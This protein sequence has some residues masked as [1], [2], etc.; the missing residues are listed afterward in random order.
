[1][2]RLILTL[3][4]ASFLVSCSN[5]IESFRGEWEAIDRSR[6]IIY[7]GDEGAQLLMQHSSSGRPIPYKF[8][9]IREG[10][11]GKAVATHTRA[12]ALMIIRNQGAP[13]ALWIEGK[14]FERVE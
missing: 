13:D 6:A 12:P 1:M 9:V 14:R 5:P 7:V 3:F 8:D 11:N 4:A 2:L 10:P